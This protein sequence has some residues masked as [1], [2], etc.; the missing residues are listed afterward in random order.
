MLFHT[1]A[2]KRSGGRTR[3]PWKAGNWICRVRERD[4]NLLSRSEKTERPKI[5]ENINIRKRDPLIMSVTRLTLS[6]R[7]DDAEKNS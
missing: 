4:F 5:S 2:H 7:V 6:S 1:S 3:G